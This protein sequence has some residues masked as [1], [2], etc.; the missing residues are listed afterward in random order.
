MST[1][2]V[3]ITVG[4]TGAVPT[5]PATLNAGLIAY[6]VGLQ[7]GLTANLPAVLIEDI[8]STA[9]GALVQ[10]DALAV[11]L[12]NS[13]TPFTSNSWL[14]TQFGNI[15]GITQ[16][17]DTNTSVFVTFSGSVGYVI[18]PGTTVSDGTYQ[19][20]VQDG[21]AIATGGASVPLF[22]VATVAGSWAVPVGTVTQIVSS[23]PTGITLTCTNTNTGTPGGT[24]Q[25]V[26]DFRAQCLQ[27]GLASAQGM[28]R[29]VKTLLNAV[30]GVQPRLVSILQVNA[31][32]WEVICGGGDPYLIA[33][34]I[35]QGSFD[36]SLFVGSTLLVTGITNA[37]L[38]V[39]T[40][41]LNHGLITGQANVFIAGVVGMTGVNGGPYTVT[42]LTQK[43]FTFGVNTNSSGPYGSGGGVTPNNRNISVN[44]IDT[45][46]TYTVPFVNPP[47]QTVTLQVTWNTTSPNFVSAT[48]VA[49]LSTPALVNYVN[50]IPVGQPI[51]LFELEDV[52][53]SSI[54]SIIP[55]QFVS[56][57]LFT[58]SIN[59]ISTPPAANTFIISGDPE[60]Y[61]FCTSA[62]V[63]V[64]QG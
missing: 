1:A 42:V 22:C 17:V 49:Q 54:S 35:Y 51:N 47:Q 12:I 24:A 61:F 34:A 26:A 18:N 13:I 6:A 38:G 44:L 28:P 48:A 8:A 4:S 58:V 50:S 59:G 29:F 55:I 46:N 53:Q 19:Y 11:D 43:T 14:T 36:I 27:A 9:T 39:V 45:P 10:I 62:N 60:S 2:T 32:G 21:G 63:T 52:F 3:S 25:S 41:N 30:P 16:G 57:M 7:P 37:T 15:Y 40:T 64:T 20:V 56:K 31:G 5:S 33:N 23:I